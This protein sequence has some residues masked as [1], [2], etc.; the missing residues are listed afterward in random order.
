MKPTE[1]PR[2]RLADPVQFLAFGFG[3]GCARRAPGTFGTVVAVALYLP[4][5]RLPLEAYL[6]VLV[7]AGLLGIWL[8]G[9]ASRRLD[10]HDHPGIVWDEIVGYL[11]TMIGVPFGLGWMLAGFVLFRIF[12]IWKPWP[13]GWLDRRVSGGLGIMID[14]ILAGGAACICLH[15]A[16]RLM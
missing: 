5:A 13:I 10:V 2:P 15:V 12:D 9:E 1:L 16:A 4:I 14:D 8:C 6:A 7:L 3:S 11:V